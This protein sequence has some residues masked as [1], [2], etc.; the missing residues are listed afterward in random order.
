[1][2]AGAIVTALGQQHPKGKQALS[3]GKVM[4]FFFF[5]VLAVIGVA[6]YRAFR[7]HA[8][9]PTCRA[10]T[11]R[12]PAAVVVT[13][14]WVEA[15]KMMKLRYRPQRGTGFPHI[16]GKVKGHKVVIT[17]FTKRVRGKGKRF[18]RFQVAY[19]R[20]LGIGLRLTREASSPVSASSLEIRTST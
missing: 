16:V 12:D 3:A 11:S 20:P 17:T 8:A 9:G 10:P 13:D 14:P 5:V 18:T 19:R 6:V 7:Q 15:A 2:N 1:M 4:E